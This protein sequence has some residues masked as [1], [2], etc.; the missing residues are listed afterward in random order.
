[1]MIAVDPENFL[2]CF[3]TALYALLNVVIFVNGFVKWCNPG[4]CMLWILSF[5]KI[6]VLC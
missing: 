5:A 1:M 3:I 6:I 2:I 4:S